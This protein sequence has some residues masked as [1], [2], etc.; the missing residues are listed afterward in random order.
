MDLLNNTLR[1]VFN[2]VP[3]VS[4]VS[5]TP[6]TIYNCVIVIA[7][8][9][10]NIIVNGNEK[11]KKMDMPD[12]ITKTVKLGLDK[13]NKNNFRK[14]VGIFLSKEPLGDEICKVNNFCQ[15]EST[16]CSFVRF[17]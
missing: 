15:F 13:N 9:G 3:V 6:N 7:N 5:I 16:E 11:L 10:I 4:V 17:K 1:L 14:K 12:L 8:N 2:G